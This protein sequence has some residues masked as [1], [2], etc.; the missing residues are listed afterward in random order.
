[1]KNAQS[2]VIQ[3]G[4]NKLLNVKLVQLEAQFGMSKAKPA[5]QNAKTEDFLRLMTIQ[6]TEFFYVRFIA[7]QR[8]FQTGTLQQKNAFKSVQQPI[9]S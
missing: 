2:L 8:P 1:V 7:H 9:Q 6:K 4:I 5:F 3:N